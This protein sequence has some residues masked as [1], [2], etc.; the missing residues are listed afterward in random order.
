MRFLFLLSIILCSSLSQASTINL[1]YSIFFNYMKTM[2][3]LDYEYVSTAFYLIDRNDNSLCNIDSAH[4]VV[5]A[6][7]DPILFERAGR[8]HPFYS[9]Q[10][11]KD[12]G[13]IVVK[14]DDLQSIST[15]DLNITVMA[16]ER[17]LSSL[18]EKKI[19]IISEQLEGVLTK[20]A[21][22]IGRYFLP[23]F[24]GLRLQLTTPLAEAQLS[25]LGEGV[26][27][28]ANG[29]LLLDN[30]ALHLITAIMAYNPTVVRITPWM[31]SE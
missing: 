6:N 20:N 26:K 10:H 1:S 2:Y 17:E 30:D 29:E 14:I 13:V 16:K 7:A 27:I 23:T 5:E 15:C 12:G 9:D 31:Q 19:R 8:L 3:K 25:S 4:L 24:A 28:A 22:M 11:R 21:G 18:N